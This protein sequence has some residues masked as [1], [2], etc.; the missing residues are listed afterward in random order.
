[1]AW[2]QTHPEPAIL[3]LIYHEDSGRLK[4]WITILTFGT[5]KPG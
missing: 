5:D 2:L 4:T 3:V 1:M